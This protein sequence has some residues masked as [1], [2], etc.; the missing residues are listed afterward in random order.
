MEDH[1]FGE[2]VSVRRCWVCCSDDLTESTWIVVGR[3]LV[4]AACI[5]GRDIPRTIAP[6]RGRAGAPRALLRAAYSK[7][8]DFKE[9]RAD[10]GPVLAHVLASTV[11]T[12]A[13]VHGLPNSAIL[14]PVPS[15]DDDRVHMQRLC[16]LAAGELSGIR[17]APVL[18]KVKDF[19]QARLTAAERR[20]A[21]KGAFEV[22][23]RVRNTS[24]IVADDIMTSGNTLAACAKTLYDKGA[25][26]VYGVALMRAMRKPD[27]GLAL[28][29][30]E[31]C[32]VEWTELDD[33]RRTGISPGVSAIW[34]RFACGRRCPFIL[35]AGPFPAPAL[36]TESLHVWQCECGV[37]H[38]IALRREWHG[39]SQETIHLGVGD[40]Q[41][42]ELL[43][44]Q[45]HLRG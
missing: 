16:A 19:R 5:R 36:G 11:M 26:E 10:N 22:R 9:G 13:A 34:A 8:V 15:Y 12:C 32:E 38:S 29:G 7:I 39:Q 21:S 2:P 23:G 37:K 24:V 40:R 31:Q 33:R 42:S 41:A 30:E 27:K 25:A 6:Y 28:F 14:V 18:R 17:I 43:I 20:A 1:P 45:R 3:R 4:C 35:T 44:A